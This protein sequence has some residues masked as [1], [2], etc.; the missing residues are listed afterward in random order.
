MRRE[1]RKPEESYDNIPR[2]CKPSKDCTF[3]PPILPPSYLSKETPTVRPAIAILKGAGNNRV[4]TPAFASLYRK[5]ACFLAKVFPPSENPQSLYPPLSAEEFVSRRFATA[6]E[7]HRHLAQELWTL[8]REISGDKRQVNLKKLY[9]HQLAHLIWAAASLTDGPTSPTSFFIQGAPGTGKTLT[10]GVLMQACIRLQQR[11][12]MKGKIAYCT[13]KPYHLSDKVRGKGMGHRRVL[14]T[15]PYTLSEKDI[16]RRRLALCRMDKQ[17]MQTFFPRKAWNALFVKRPATE[18]E[19]CRVIDDYFQDAGLSAAEADTEML[20][21]VV[22]VV[23]SLATTV[24]GPSGAT[25]LLTL[26]PVPNVTQQIESHTGDAAFA[27]PPDYPVFARENIGIST[28]TRG[29]ARVVLEPALMFTSVR[30]IERY[31]EELHRH[32][33]VILCDEAQRRQPLAFQE[34]VVSAGAEQVPLLFAAG[35]QWYGKAWNRRSPMHSFPESIRR[36]ILPDLGV[37][38]F[39]SAQALHF[40]SETEEAVEQLIKLFFQPL[41]NFK[42]LGLPQPYDVNTLV[43][44]HGRLVDPMVERLRQAYV[45]RGASATVR[46]FH[47]NEED[48]EAL[49]IWFDTE[50][51]GPHV[52][53]SS[54]AIVKESLD[55]LSLRHLAVGAKV[56]ADVLYHLIGRLAHGR[57][58]RNKTDRMLVTLQQFANS[59]LAATPFLA[60]DHGQTFSDEGF[61]WIN[62]HALMS[63]RAFQQDKRRLARKKRTQDRVEVPSHGRRKRGMPPPIKMASGTSLLPGK[64]GQV[65]DPTVREYTNPLISKRALVPI[66][67][68]TYDPKKGPPSKELTR[69]W[70]AECDGLAVFDNY[71][72]IML[73]VEEA[74]DSGSDPRHAL[75]QKLAHLRERYS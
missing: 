46:P 55:L 43:V 69:M 42:E 26:P 49:Q 19:A 62:G 23:A 11:Q 41:S 38:I 21:N 58:L 18:D 48:R 9:D 64:N 36:G 1:L 33:Q 6:P 32:V 4:P 24:R 29:E 47:G 5:L 7:F 14:R 10:L 37:R 34:P 61:T 20:A 22:K 60:L 66:A 73:A 8:L 35:S 40:P 59:N 51:E 28:A 54:A 52:L 27:I 39:P 15:P 70:A 71:P 72:S 57:S 12:L 45:T 44:V 25:E 16:N 56:S 68:E 74:H 67:Q 75:E 63:A 30:Q 17:F 50:G 13:A 2:A 65:I 31:Q 3:L 53:V